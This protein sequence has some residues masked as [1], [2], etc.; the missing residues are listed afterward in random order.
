[1]NPLPLRA[2]SCFRVAAANGGTV[3]DPLMNV[4]LTAS[5]GVDGGDAGATAV[6]F[7]GCD[8][9]GGAAAGGDAAEETPGRFGAGGGTVS[10]PA[11]AR[12]G[13][14]AAGGASAA[15]MVAL[16]AGVPGGAGGAGGAAVPRP[17]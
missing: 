1:M 8:G 15:G 3:A 17:N 11:A 7:A 16:A 9:D 6:A 14:G 10:G 4:T 2:A 5:P 12:L 13:A